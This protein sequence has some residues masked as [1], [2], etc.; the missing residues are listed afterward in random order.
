ML[1]FTGRV[2]NCHDTHCLSTFG[3]LSHWHGDRCVSPMQ[4]VCVCYYACT[5]PCSTNILYST[6]TNY[7]S[8]RIVCAKEFLPHFLWLQCC[9]T[10]GMS[11]LFAIL[12]HHCHCFLNSH[13]PLL[14]WSMVRDHFRS[15]AYAHCFPS[16]CNL[17]FSHPLSTAFFFHY[18][19]SHKHSWLLFLPFMLSLP[20]SVMWLCAMYTTAI[21]SHFPSSPLFPGTVI[22]GDHR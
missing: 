1:S 3:F 4:Q 10:S 20:F 8:L 16:F 14:P 19:F 6:V 5:V 22:G 13:P 17:Q 7:A 18:F 2:V 11:C 9:T 21:S 15:V 12:F